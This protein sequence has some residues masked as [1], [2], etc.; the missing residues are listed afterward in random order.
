MSP[1]PCG[2]RSR[3]C[4]GSSRKPLHPRFRWVWSLPDQECN[5]AY[6]CQA[7]WRSF[8]VLV[9]FFPLAA[10]TMQASKPCLSMESWN[11]AESSTGKTCAK[12]VRNLGRVTGAGSPGRLCEKCAEGGCEQTGGDG[13][14][15]GGPSSILVGQSSQTLKGPPKVLPH[16]KRIFCGCGYVHR[17]LGQGRVPISRSRAKSGDR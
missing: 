11:P 16:P 13:R 4:G 6:R 7:A 15:A 2:V 17:H 5:L 1:G 12:P 8:P 9:I 14:A 3:R 10:T